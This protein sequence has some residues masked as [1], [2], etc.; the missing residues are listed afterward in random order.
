VLA[1]ETRA[2]RMTARAEGAPT[3]VLVRPGIDGELA[4]VQAKLLL[5]V[6]A[7]HFEPKEDALNEAMR[8]TI[9]GVDV[10]QGRFGHA[11][12]NR[13]G[14]RNSLLFWRLAPAQVDLGRGLTVRVDLKLDE[15]R[16]ATVL[17]IGQALELLL[18]DDLRPRAR[19]RL[20]TGAS[21][22]SVAAVASDVTL[23]LRQWCTLEAAFD[24]EAAVLV[25]DGLEI[26]RVPAEGIA[27][28]DKD[29]ALDVSPGAAAVPGAVD[30]VRL[31]VFTLAP[32]QYLPAGLQPARTYRFAY[33]ARGEA[34]SD[35]AIEWIVH[36]ETQ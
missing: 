36:G 18:D 11:R 31:A 12:R 25:L 16:S 24:G 26:A 10:P 14:D 19:L 28:Q 1:G 15:R 7:F 3:E 22:S 32:L 6:A 35:P 13:D 5:P 2:A 29:T 30:E 34:T 23:P 4:T 8:P 20:E 21:G 33:D 17:R 9:G 27:V